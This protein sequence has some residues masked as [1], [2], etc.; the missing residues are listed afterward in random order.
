MARCVTGE[1]QETAGV[2]AQ[3]EE[4]ALDPVSWDVELPDD[5]Q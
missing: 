5:L 1:K 3:H 4:G 2:E